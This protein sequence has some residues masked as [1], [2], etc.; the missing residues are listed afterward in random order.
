MKVRHR[1]FDSI[2]GLRSINDLGLGIRNLKSKLPY[3]KSR[4]VTE[5]GAVATGYLHPNHATEG[6]SVAQLHPVA[7]A[8]G[9]VLKWRPELSPSS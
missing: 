4:N 9:S 1:V 6:S 5:P 3:L 2:T 8:P 7:T